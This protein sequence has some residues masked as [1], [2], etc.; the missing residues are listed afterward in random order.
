M[1]EVAPIWT[2]DVQQQNYRALLDAM[3]RP[4][5]VKPIFSQG[6]DDNTTVAVLA[7]LLDGEVSLADPHGLV[8]DTHWPLLQA[9][10]AAPENA[11]Y[12]VCAGNQAPDFEPKLGTLTS[13][14][15]SASL[16]I[17]VDS[18]AQGELQLR[19]TGPGVDGYLTNT[20][21]GLHRQWL[22]RRE[23]WVCAFPLGVDYLLL[24][25]CGVLALPR[26]TRVEVL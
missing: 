11:D 7:T 21:S 24:D 13:P 6:Q 15:H 26:T 23:K 10:S 4:G 22:S 2:A 19:I 1:L 5:Q 14:E 9:M 20:L 3:S 17:Q 12:I 25:N 8:W 16:I 18:L